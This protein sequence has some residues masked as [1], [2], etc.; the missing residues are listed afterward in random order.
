MVIIALIKSVFLFM[1][2]CTHCWSLLGLPKPQ[3]EL[4]SRLK[5]EPCA[6]L[7]NLNQKSTHFQ[8]QIVTKLL[9]VNPL[10]ICQKIK[11]SKF[12]S[13]FTYNYIHVLHTNFMYSIK[14]NDS[15]FNRNKSMIIWHFPISPTNLITVKEV[16]S[17]DV[18]F[19]GS[20]LHTFYT[21]FWW[22]SFLNTEVLSNVI[23]RLRTEKP[24]IV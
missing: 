1:C 2:T 7:L 15:Y 21:K 4:N 5:S 11:Q 3:K 22:P 8:C 10:L 16:C 12:L 17:H 6:M 20:D 13:M 24:T 18:A 19:I 9:R 14:W 23:S